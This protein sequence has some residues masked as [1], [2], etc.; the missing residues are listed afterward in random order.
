M[1]DQLLGVASSIL[2][3]GATGLLGTVITGGFAFLN[4]RQRHRQEMALRELDLQIMQS[5]AAGAE[6]IAAIEAEGA[7]E[8]AAYGA[9][10]ASY[11]AAS[12][13]WSRPGEGWAMV[14]VDVVRGLMR[15][16]LTLGLLGLTA[17][18]YFE[19]MARPAFM[20]ALQA[21]IVDTVLYLVTAA[22]LWWFGQRGVDKAISAKGSR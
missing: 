22:V 11:K 12:Q 19:M 14:A 1:L 17:Y 10:E 7:S 21:R 13:R 4:S 16:V 9:L 15:P 8:Q 20:T 3:G 18:I 2:T 5:E 6:R